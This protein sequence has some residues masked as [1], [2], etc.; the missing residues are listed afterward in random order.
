MTGSYIADLVVLRSRSLFV[1]HYFTQG[2]NSFYGV[3][4][5]SK[6]NVI[7]LKGCHLREGD[8]NIICIQPLIS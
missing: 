3:Y 5:K 8:I 6:W 4:A 7:F 1:F 2:W